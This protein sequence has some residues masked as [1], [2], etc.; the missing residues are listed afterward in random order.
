MMIKIGIQNRATKVAATSGD[1]QE[2]VGRGVI[3]E[4][5][6][7]VGEASTLPGQMK[8][9]PSWRE[10]EAEFCAGDDGGTARFGL[11]SFPPGRYGESWL[12]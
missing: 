5:L 11:T 12:I 4:G 8:L 1:L 10:F 2:S 7:E 9:P 6:A 3:T